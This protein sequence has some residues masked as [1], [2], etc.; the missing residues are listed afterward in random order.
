MLAALTRGGRGP[1]L[2]ALVSLVVVG[3]AVVSQVWGGLSPCTLCWY[4]RYPYG[5]TILLGLAGAVV[6]GQG[7]PRAAALLT[8]GCGLAFAIG[9][10]IAAL[11]VGVEQ[12][13]WEWASACTGVGAGQARTV[14]ELRQLLETAPVVR[15]DE[16]QWSLFGISMAGY[17]LLASLALLA[18]AGFVAHTLEQRAR[19]QER[20]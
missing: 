16:V 6:T 3:S 5:V 10:T 19:A 4:Q 14:D 11:H 8:L 13:W 17:N 12:D 9:A 18:F 2:I 1:A 15:C 20:P 7:R